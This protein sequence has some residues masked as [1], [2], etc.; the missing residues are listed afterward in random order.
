MFGLWGQLPNGQEIS[1]GWKQDGLGRGE[2]LP[3]VFAQF[4]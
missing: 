3:R 4:T 2:I 1:M